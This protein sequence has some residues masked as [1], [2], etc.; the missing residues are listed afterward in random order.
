MTSCASTPATGSGAKDTRTRLQIQM[1]END[2]AEAR[3]AYGRVAERG[4]TL[5]DF[6]AGIIV[7]RIHQYRDEFNNG[8]PFQDAGQVMRGRHPKY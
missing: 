5:G 1:S 2:L 3:T 4:Q 8:H 7:E 6:V